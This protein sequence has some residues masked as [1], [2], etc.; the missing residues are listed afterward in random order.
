M[1]LPTPI[2][3][4]IV[5]ALLVALAGCSGKS[6]P[7]KPDAKPGDKKD[8]TQPGTTTPGT[9]TPGTT[10]PGTTPPAPA[11]TAYLKHDDPAQAEAGKV[12]KDLREGTLGADRLSVAFLKVIGKPGPLVFD[13]DKK[14][15]Y[16]IDE[17]TKWLKRAGAGLPGLGFPTG[18]GG[19][20]VAVFTT[21]LVGQPGQILVRLVQDGAA[22]KV[23]WVQFAVVNATEPRK[24]ESADEPFRAFAVQAFVDAITTG[25][26]AMDRADRVPVLAAVL[27]AKLKKQWAAPFASDTAEGFGYN[28]GALGTQADT[29]GTGIEG[30]SLTPTGADTFTVEITRSGG[31]KK[32]HT[33]KLVKGA[34]PGEWL[35]DEFTP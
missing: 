26:K 33:V 34:A 24:A 31:M 22:W 13:D 5:A 11:G 27:S 1:T 28:R 15:G 19:G 4:A 25:P 21:S 35:V 3:P 8:T 20:G 32:T 16:S 23:D 10:T 14:R 9:T 2:R 30:Y 7:T 18:Y 12:L 6:E 29:L 17:A